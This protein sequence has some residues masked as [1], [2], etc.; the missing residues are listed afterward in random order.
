LRL[1]LLALGL[2]SAISRW[3]RPLPSLRPRSTHTPRRIGVWTALTYMSSWLGIGLF[4]DGNASVGSLGA[5]LWWSRTHINGRSGPLCRCHV[6]SPQR[7]CGVFLKVLRQVNAK[8]RDVRLAL[9]GP[10]VDAVSD[11]PEGAKVLDECLTCWENLSSRQRSAVRL[12]TLPMD[13][14]ELN[15]LMVN[16]IQRHATVVVQKI[17]KRVRS[18]GCEA[19]WKSPPGRGICGWWHC[20]PSGARNGSPTERPIGPGYL[21][22]DTRRIC[23]RDRRRWR[24]WDAGRGNGFGP[25][26]S[27][28][29]ISLTTRD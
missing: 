27:V 15:A 3:R 14:F 18:H 6:G 9:V 20:R 29:A 5:V 10:A 28:T 26:S 7:Y 24:P 11:D 22:Q 2:R 4:D 23:W 8:Q 13:N 12:I 16:A 25:I 17:W 19:M 1:R 21:R